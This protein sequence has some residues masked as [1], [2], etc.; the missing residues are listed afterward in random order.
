MDPPPPKAPRLIPMA[1]PAAMAS[2][3]ITPAG[4]PGPSDPDRPCPPQ[5]A[6]QGEVA[7]RRCPTSGSAPR[8]RPGLP[9]PSNP[10][11]RSRCVLPL[12][13][14]QRLAAVS[15]GLGS[16]GHRHGV[17]AS[18]RRPPC[19]LQRAVP[20]GTDHIHPPVTW[21]L[22]CPAGQLAQ[23]D[24]A[25]AGHVPSQVLVGLPYVDHRGPIGPEG[26][27]RRDVHLVD[28]AQPPLYTPL[29]IEHTAVGLVPPT[30]GTSLR[31]VIL[32]GPGGAAGWH[33]APAV[34]LGRAGGFPSPDGEMPLA[35]S[36]RLVAE[37]CSAESAA[38]GGG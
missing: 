7:G 37:R 15:P 8:R 25:C 16:P 32:P 18:R 24:E 13:D 6:P 33:Q 30:P 2:A 11:D 1:T 27:K 29:G 38:D 4:R 9:A 3:N 20:R 14:D 34:V 17:V 22:G 35:A 26:R 21:H 23:G 10:A 19:R 36:G 28:H 31:R 12:S 5:S